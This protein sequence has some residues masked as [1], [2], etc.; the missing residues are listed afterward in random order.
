MKSQI[1]L[2]LKADTPRVQNLLSVVRNLLPGAHFFVEQ[3]GRHALTQLPQGITAVAAEYFEKQVQVVI[4]LG[5][6]GTMIH[7]ASLLQNKVIP[8]LGIN[9]GNLG[10]LAEVTEEE[11]PKVL[12]NILSGDL[13]YYDRMRLD[14]KI[15]RSNEILLQQRILNDAV[16]NLQALARLA[17]Y[18]VTIDSHLVTTM[19]GDG[20]IVA[21]PTGSTAYSLAAG[22]AILA[23]T[24]HAVAITPICPHA[25][26][27]RPLVVAPEGEICVQLESPSLVFATLDGQQG[28][29]F[30]QGD[31]MLIQQAPIPTRLLAVP[32]R[33]YF[34]TLRTKLRW[35]AENI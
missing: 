29:E 6:D 9:L 25:L 11:M 23:P 2:V 18:R 8:I 32:W 16:L 12:P 31:K 10:F 15:I 33:D 19:R 3:E 27:Q 4:V 14:V 24:L 17:I 1:G 35:G 26:S 7:A 30:R 5:G 13:P 34:Q 20:L 22:G 28:V 21:T